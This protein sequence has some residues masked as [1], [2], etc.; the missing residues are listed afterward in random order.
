MQVQT[1][2]RNNW[3]VIRLYSINF[4]SN[5]KRE[6]KKIKEFLDKLTSSGKVTAN[7]FKRA[8]KFAKLPEKTV[9]ASYILNGEN[10]G[11]VMRVIKAVVTAEEPISQQYLLKRTLSFF[12][13][14]KWG[15]K[16]E[17]KIKSLA[18]NCGFKS[19]QM[20]GNVYYFKNDKFASYDR[21]RVEEGT[22]VRSSDT[23]F[24]PY[25]VI[26][27]V[28]A[29]LLDKV[30]MYVDELVP[31]VVKQFKVVRSSDKLNSFIYSCIGDGVR[32]GL[33]IRSISDKISLA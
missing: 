14:T 31:L 32:Q 18:D 12:G 3:S 23:D 26:S 19:Q 13:I 22:A 7:N 17:G 11:E 15:S 4:F 9:E 1:L 28:K 8:Y 2:K 29:I 20:L 30:S 24:T 6:I 21:Y 25:D 5:P 33:F 27:L 10:D 16:L